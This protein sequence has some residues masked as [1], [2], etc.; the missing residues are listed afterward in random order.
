MK[1]VHQ[2]VRERVTILWRLVRW[3]VL[4]VVVCVPLVR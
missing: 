1:H 3:L 4:V 2:I